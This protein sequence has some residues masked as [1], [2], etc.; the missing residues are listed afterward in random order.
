M[1]KQIVLLTIAL[2]LAL[3][4][5]APDTETV[6]ACSGY[7]YFGVS[8]LPT[9]EMLVK[10]TVIDT[11]DRGFNAVLR[12][13]KYYKG[14]GDRYI[15]VMRYPA[16]LETGALYR[17]Y[18]TSC[19]YAGRGHRFVKGSQGYFGLQ[20]NND[21]T[22]TDDIYGTAHFYVADGVITYE[23][24][25]TEGY[26]LEFNDEL[27]ITEEEFI[28]LLLEAGERTAPIEPDI[29]AVSHYP[30]MRFINITTENGTR[31]QINPDRSV[32]EYPYVDVLD[33][34]LDGSHVAVRVDEERVGFQYI[35]LSNQFTE[36]ADH[37]SR[38]FDEDLHVRMGKDVKFTQDSSLAAVWNE[39]HIAVYMMNNH[40]EVDYAYGQ[41]LNLTTVANI[42]LPENQEDL[43]RVLWSADSST[44]VWEDVSGVYHWNLYDAAEHSTVL[45]HEEIVD[46]IPM[47]SQ[48]M[49]VSMYGRYVKVGHP[50]EWY[51]VDMVT[52]ETSAQL[53][54]TPN[55]QFLVSIPSAYDEN[56]LERC[57]PPLRN[58][59]RVA[60]YT[61]SSGSETFVY[62]QHMQGIRRCEAYDDIN[63]CLVSLSSAHPSINGLLSD[64][65][66]E[67]VRDILYD[68][69][70]DQA[71][72][73]V[74]DYQVHLNFDDLYWLSYEDE[75]DFETNHLPYLDIL[76]L[77]D[78]LDSPIVSIEWGQY[79]FYDAY[80]LVTNQ[81]AP[82]N[83]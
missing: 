12:V 28:E 40:F 43:P 27:T 37:R 69:Q 63:Y 82:T 34:S 81:F 26:A 73:V 32:T 53:L 60:A 74:G 21:G 51:L 59:C 13:E 24:G 48:L 44:L 47:P 15:T 16:G 19:L 46:L 83:E 3:S 33:V 55:E 45:T 20:D 49:N 50:G 1:L 68:P 62:N 76:F 79:V 22:F 18:D 52:G 67:D 57:V 71:A 75:D 41:Q 8:D 30:L 36:D 64:A 58:N 2:V 35:W 72:L 4:F 70:Y 10:A 77:E 17:G 80:A 61:G 5:L 25:A 6:Q 42:D 29:E 11:D 38:Y 54:V 65:Y 56:T 66:F 14:G 31:Y 39:D 23:E 9:A 78:V 7:P